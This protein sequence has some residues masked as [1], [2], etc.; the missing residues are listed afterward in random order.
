MSQLAVENSFRKAK[1]YLNIKDYDN[2]S[3]IY[4]DILNIYPKN[5]RAQNFL[6]NLNEKLFQ[7]KL[8]EFDDFFSKNQFLEAEKKGDEIY[9]NHKEDV[10]FLRLF[11][12]IKANLNKMEEAKEIFLQ[13]LKSETNPYMTLKIWKCILFTKDYDQ[14]IILKI[15]ERKS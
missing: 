6:K 12:T 8:E 5:I 3:K 10:K 1:K 14:Y 9:K 2:A 15:N 11:G 7:I 13:L 4:K